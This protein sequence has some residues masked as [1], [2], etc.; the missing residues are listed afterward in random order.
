M[1]PRFRM[2]AK[3]A[4]SSFLID[5]SRDFTR[6]AELKNGAITFAADPFPD[7]MLEYFDPQ[8]V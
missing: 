3:L 8:M 2:F 7:W 1:Q 6:I 4:G 5:N